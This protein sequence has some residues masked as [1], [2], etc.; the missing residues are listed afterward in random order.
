VIS[1]AAQ[2]AKN[3]LEINESPSAM[4]SKQKNA[5]AEAAALL[6]VAALELDPNA[7]L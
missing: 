2:Q 3:S 7:Q 5:A 6:R 1:A 4:E